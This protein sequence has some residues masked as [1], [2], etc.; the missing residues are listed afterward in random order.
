MLSGLQRGILSQRWRL[1]KVKKTMRPPW[2]AA[3]PT[4]P[5]HRPDTLLTPFCV[6][7]IIVAENA[8]RAFAAGGG[9]LNA[10]HEHKRSCA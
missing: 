4:P 5:R 9:G 8:I 1:L 10:T 6:K 2:G 7:C 3:A